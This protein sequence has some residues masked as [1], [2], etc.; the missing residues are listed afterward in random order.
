[1]NMENS[2]MDI[3]KEVFPFKDE[4]LLNEVL[5]YASDKPF[6][7]RAIIISEGSKYSNIPFLVSGMAK[8]YFKMADGKEVTDCFETKPGEVLAAFYRLHM[9]SPEYVAEVSMMALTDCTVLYV[10]VN[11]INKIA[12]EYIEAILLYNRMLEDSL[13]WHSDVKRMLYITKPEERYKWFCEK[14]PELVQLLK[15]KKI[16]QKEIASY[17]NMTEQTF[18]KIYSQ[19]NKD[20]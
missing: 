13:E 3:V 2:M 5:H 16:K 8:G 18:S 17:L 12:T 19:C 14:Y 9:D 7:A 15:E 6:P 1:M 4:N 20:G 10:P 11:I